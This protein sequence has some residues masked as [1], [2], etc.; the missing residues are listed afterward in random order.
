MNTETEKVRANA[1]RARATGLR[2][3]G[4][5]TAAR[6][7][8]QVTYQGKNQGATSKKAPSV[9][10]DARTKVRVVGF[11]QSQIALMMIPP[12]SVIMLM[13]SHSFRLDKRDSSE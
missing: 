3:T 2:L 12:A 10:R 5:H 11:R 13:R 8:I 6:A 1:T 4:R 9:R 7:T